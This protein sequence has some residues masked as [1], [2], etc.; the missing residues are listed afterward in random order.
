MDFFQVVHWIDRKPVALQQ[1]RVKINRRPKQKQDCWFHSPPSD[2]WDL[3][4]HPLISP[5]LIIAL[6]LT[7]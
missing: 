4:E 3:E 5:R 6:G 1:T 2:C 7:A